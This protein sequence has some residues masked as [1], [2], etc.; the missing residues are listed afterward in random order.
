MTILQLSAQSFVRPETTL[1]V[2][3]LA[4]A[5]GITVTYAWYLDDDELPHG[6]GPRF[7]WSP[8]LYNSTVTARATYVDANGVAVE[9]SSQPLKVNAAPT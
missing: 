2:V 7:V 4:L 3:P 1:E 6:T 8:N 9:V 5:A